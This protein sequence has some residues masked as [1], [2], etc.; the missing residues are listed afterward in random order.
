MD[1]AS[2]RKYLFEELD[3]AVAKL[4]KVK[5]LRNPER[6]GLVGARLMGARQATGDVLV[7]LDAHCE[8]RQDYYILLVGYIF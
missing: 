2:D 7:F 6:K 5:I 1:D 8:V 3:E 4:D